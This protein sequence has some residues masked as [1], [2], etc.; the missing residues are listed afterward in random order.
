MISIVNARGVPGSVGALARGPR[1]ERYFISCAHVLYGGGAGDGDRVLAVEDSIGRRVLGE[2]G[3]TM[4]G[5][6]GCITHGGE[7]YFL[8]CA[9][10]ALADEASLPPAV[11]VALRAC[12]HSAGVASVA[13]GARVYKD[14]WITGRTHGHV[15]DVAWFDR[16]VFDGQLRAAPNQI[17]IRP[18]N[19]EESF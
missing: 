12:V 11:R 18:H 17:L 4:R 15:I 14:G 7:S 5:Y 10:G 19:E 6:L 2:L 13:Q 8:D 16:P 9:I 3:S 1:G